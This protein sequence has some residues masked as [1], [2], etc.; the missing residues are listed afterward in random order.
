M[1]RTALPGWLGGAT[2]QEY[3][4]MAHADHLVECHTLLGAQCAGMAIYRRN[5][6]KF[7]APPTL[8]L[9]ADRELCFASRSEFL[10]HHEK[11]PG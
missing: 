4:A 7:C 6:V 10:A 5:V 1:A 8:R 3:A 2:P 9:P 11:G